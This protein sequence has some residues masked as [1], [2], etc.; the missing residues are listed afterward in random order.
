MDCPGP[1]SEAGLST[2]PNSC[3]LP[4]VDW[5]GIGTCLEE[6]EVEREGTGE[7]SRAIE[8]CLDPMSAAGDSERLAGVDIG[9]ERFGWY[10]GPSPLSLLADDAISQWTS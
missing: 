1:G 7:A 10:D 3:P 4:A 6:Y 2:R 5:F 9:V 8:A